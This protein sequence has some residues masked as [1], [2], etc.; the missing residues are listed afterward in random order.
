[1]ALLLGTMLH[2]CAA[3]SVMQGIS[4]R[5]IVSRVSEKF[6]YVVVVTRRPLW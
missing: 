2:T 6:V 1:M 3:D 4:R 5:T